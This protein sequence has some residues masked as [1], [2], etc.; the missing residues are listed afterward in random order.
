[1][2]EIWL[3]GVVGE[4]GY[5][6]VSA[7]DV[8]DELAK[9]RKSEPVVVRINSPGGSVF[10]GVSIR[11]QL[12]EWPGGVDV[13]VDG[14]SASIASYI[15]TV[16]RTVAIAR[17]G[18]IM[19]H[20]AWTLIAGNSDDLKRASE[21]LDQTSETL[22]SAYVAKTGKTRSEIRAMMKRET[23]FTAAGAVEYGLADIVVGEDG[24]AAAMT[25]TAARAK[26]D[27]LQRQ[28][29]ETYSRLGV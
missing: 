24:R 25:T 19:C 15:G 11:T 16:G 21:H 17:D 12:A 10:E 6:D 28:L 18:Q 26:L 20:D 3:Y 14:L 23:W 1:M 29:D 2:Q 13:Q 22:V 7:L 8:R 9:F 27:Q 5:G 4:A